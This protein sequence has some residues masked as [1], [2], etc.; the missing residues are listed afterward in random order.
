M[1]RSTSMVLLLAAAWL[2][3]PVA[4]QSQAATEPGAATS[5]RT[6]A[7]DIEA[8]MRAAEAALEQAARRI[9]ELTAQRLP[10]PAGQQWDFGF[11]DR[12]MLGITID[13]ESDGGPVEG[14][15]VRGVSPGGAAF[16]AGLRAGDIITAINK[17]PLSAES[18]AAANGKLLD[19]MAGVESGDTL[20]VDYLRDGKVATVAIEPRGGSEQRF[21]FALRGRGPSGLAAPHAPMAPGAP[22]IRK[23]ISVHRDP[24]WRDMELVPLTEDLGRYFGADSGLLVVRAPEDGTLQLR[25]GDVIR[26]IDGREPTSIAH[27]VRILGSYQPGEKLQLEIMR[28]KRRRTLEV[29]IPDARQSRLLKRQAP[30]VMDFRRRI[31]RD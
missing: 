3:V 29:E 25:D 30:L 17:E 14:V 9:A 7:T 13:G 15:V 27:A 28:D 20:D 4:A 22:Q 2:S 26:S 1:M 10:T 16:D 31:T 5:A 21:A 18:S 19:F 12:P 8:E 11:A 6:D 24:V 23:F